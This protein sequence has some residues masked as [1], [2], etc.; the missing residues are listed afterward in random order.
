MATS[1][2]KAEFSS[3][4]AFRQR[5]SSG[6]SSAESSTLSTFGNGERTYV[7]QNV[8]D[9]SQWQLEIEYSDHILTVYGS[10]RWPDKDG[11]PRPT[12]QERRRKIMRG[13]QAGKPRT[14]I[15]STET[16]NRYVATMTLLGGK[17]MR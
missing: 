2:T 12:D 6:P 10:N 9:G 14:D 7:N 15:Y 11:I 5:L 3:L 8:F 13:D 16:L 1:S 4:S 17:S